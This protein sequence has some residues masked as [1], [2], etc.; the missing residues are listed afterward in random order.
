M[1]SEG[2]D[3]QVNEPELVAYRLINGLGVVNRVLPK[4]R[5]ICSVYQVKSLELFGSAVK[6]PFSAHSD[7]DLLISFEP[8]PLEDYFENYINFKNSLEKLFERKVDLLE[9][10][11]LKNPYLIQSIEEGKLKLYGE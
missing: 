6:G 2:I 9:K 10:Q 3:S 11:T 1:N 5:E 8:I 4:L 7:I